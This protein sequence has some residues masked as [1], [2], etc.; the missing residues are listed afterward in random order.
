MRSG[1]R[2]GLLETM[3]ATTPATTPLANDVPLPRRYGA[4]IVG[5]NCVLIVEPGAASE[6]RCVPGA[7]R[8]GLARPSAAV[9]PCELK[10]G[11]A[12]SPVPTVPESKLAPTVM[13]YGSSPGFEI[14]AAP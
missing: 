8:S 6:T 1:E 12:S 4:G 3:S 2:P 7:R 13:T 10:L 11:I 5:G 9:G 14:V